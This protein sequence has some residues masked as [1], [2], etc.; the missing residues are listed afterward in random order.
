MLLNGF[1]VGQFYQ[2]RLV[3]ELAAGSDCP[4]SAIY[5]LDYIGQGGSWPRGVPPAATLD[6]VGTSP[7]EQGLSYGVEDWAAQI[8]TFIDEVIQPEGKIAIGG[9]SVG[10]HIACVLAA[11]YPHRIDSIVLFNATPVWGGLGAK[12]PSFVSSWDGVLP[13]PKLERA[14]GRFLYDRIRGKFC[15]ERSDA[16]F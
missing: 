8:L 13:A 1:G 12:L 6:D 9:N 15:S 2:K 11:R 5:T 3:D 10:G 7:N 14:V 4:V 16:C